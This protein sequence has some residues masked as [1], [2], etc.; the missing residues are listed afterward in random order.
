MESLEI[1]EI[2]DNLGYDHH[3]KGQYDKAV[4]CYHGAILARESVVGATTPDSE[5]ATLL[6][7]LAYAYE[8]Q[9]KLAKARDLKQQARNMWTKLGRG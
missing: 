7:Y 5:M 3:K 4:A 2:L 6:Y 8:G 9:N 1:M